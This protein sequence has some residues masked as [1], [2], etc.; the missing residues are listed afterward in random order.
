MSDTEVAGLPVK[1]LLAAPGVSPALAKLIRDAG[2]D[3]NGVLS[4]AEFIEAVRKEHHFDSDRRLFRRIV[5][6]LVVVVVVLV[7]TLTGMTYGIVNLSQDME[8]SPS[9]NTLMSKAT[10]QDLYMSPGALSLGNVVYNTTA[11]AAY[12]NASA[13]TGQQLV[14][15]GLGSQLQYAGD[16]SKE[17]IVNGCQLLLGGSRSFTTFKGTGGN[18]TVA[19]VNVSSASVA[20]CQAATSSGNVTGLFALVTYEG[21]LYDVYCVDNSGTCQLFLPPNTTSANSNTTSPAPPNSTAS[22]AGGRRRLL[23]SALSADSSLLHFKAGEEIIECSTAG[24]EDVSEL[25]NPGRGLRYAVQSGNMPYLVRM[26]PK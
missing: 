13:A 26:T 20:T 3:G 5:I 21:K 4:V 25:A 2:A 10:G 8:V 1:Q 19:T 14:Q 12:A 24:C 23:S 7:G 18:M 17:A 16:I 11:S 6:A 15:S 9:S 22:V